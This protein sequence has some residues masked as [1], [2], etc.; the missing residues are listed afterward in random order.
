MIIQYGSYFN[1][2]YHLVWHSVATNP[3]QGRIRW[4]INPQQFLVDVT[5]FRSFTWIITVTV[6]MWRTDHASWC[7]CKVVCDGSDPTSMWD[8]TSSTSKRLTSRYSLMSQFLKQIIDNR[9][10][11]FPEEQCRD[12][13]RKPHRMSHSQKQQ[14]DRNVVT[15]LLWAFVAVILSSGICSSSAS[16]S[17]QHLLWIRY[18][19]R[20]YVLVRTRTYSTCTVPGTI[21]KVQLRGRVLVRFIT[22]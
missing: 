9:F 22:L 20:T 5:R 10:G 21:T 4:F 13:L 18:W 14:C 17:W 15:K 2:F 3:V 6:W 1:L 16:S 11:S 7:Y 8:E 12:N 19:V